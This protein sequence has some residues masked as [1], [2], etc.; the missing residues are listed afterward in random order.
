[1]EE[2]SLKKTYYT[3]YSIR[4]TNVIIGLK[5]KSRTR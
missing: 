5:L 2:A 3:N 1:M 4:Y